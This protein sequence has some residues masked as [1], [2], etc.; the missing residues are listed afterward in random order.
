MSLLSC[1]IS[2]IH[3]RLFQLTQISQSLLIL[4][5][6]FS[7]INEPN[8]LLSCFIPIMIYFNADTEKS[9]ILSDNK[10][11]TAIYMWIHNES[12]KRYLGSA[13]DLFKRMYLYFSI[14]YLERNKTMYIYNA[15]FH[16]GYSSFSLTILE[17]INISQIYL[18]K[19]HVN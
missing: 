15:L 9:K 13:F 17:Y 2:E 12:G 18:R 16:H 10:G 19:M 11:R 6:N 3:G 1:Y 5:G 8:I 7:F 14:K 4:K